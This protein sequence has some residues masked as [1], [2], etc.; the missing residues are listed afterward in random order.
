MKTLISIIGIITMGF[1]VAMNAPEDSSPNTKDTQ[2]LIF[3]GYEGEYYFFS[4]ASH[5]AV[6]LESDSEL[7]KNLKNND[8]VGEQFE[9]AYEPK[10]QTATSSSQGTI[11]A[12][13][14]IK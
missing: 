5:Q 4:D 11:A 2:E 14:K 3:D 13:K 12:I 1:S 9:V 10:I 6:V 7:T 8:A